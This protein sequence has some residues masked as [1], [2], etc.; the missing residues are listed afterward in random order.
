MSKSA[1]KKP[2]IVNTASINK[3]TDYMP[4]GNFT[5]DKNKTVLTQINSNKAL[6]DAKIESML[7]NGR[8]EIHTRDELLLYPLGSL[9]SY[10]TVEGLYRSG[11]FLR[12]IKDVY[13]ALGGGTFNHP[14][15]FCVQFENVQAMYVGPPIFNTNRKGQKTNFKVK[16]GKKV[17]YYAKDNYDRR[18]FKNTQRYKRMKSIYDIYGLV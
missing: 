8:K 11:G 6:F 1:K 3:N 13:F 4:E 14:V 10:V 15:S 16:I 2:N 12:A 9:V 17:V 7:E 5:Y 18:R